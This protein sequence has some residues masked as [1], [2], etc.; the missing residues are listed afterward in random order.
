MNESSLYLLGAVILGLIIIFIISAIRKTSNDKVA[1]IVNDSIGALSQL[2]KELVITNKNIDIEKKDFISSSLIIVERAV[3][4]AEQMYK[5]DNTVDRR[6]AAL[7][8]IFDVL[9]ESGI[10]VNDNRTKIIEE[11]VLSYVN[12]LPK[13]KTTKK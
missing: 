13:T 1:Q 7:S 6:G 4:A 11:L 5:E 12:E 9:L 2:A 8:F 10:E 3:K